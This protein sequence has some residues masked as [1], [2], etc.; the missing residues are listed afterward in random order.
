MSDLRYFWRIIY[1]S[2]GRQLWISSRPSRRAMVAWKSA[3]IGNPPT[4]T[5]SKTNTCGI[6]ILSIG[7]VESI[8]RV[9]GKDSIERRFFLASLPRCAQRL[10]KAIR[11]HW[12]VENPL[13][14]SLNVTFRE[15]D[16]RARTNNAAQ[17]LAML[18]RIV[19][20]LLKKDRSKKCSLRQKRLSAANNTNFLQLL[21]GI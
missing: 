20:N 15:D 1:F 13:H 18:R 14:W 8:R 9:N 6:R 4:L 12:G 7:M 2:R 21:L 11:G 17:N 19:L 16:S 5:G 3:A 10:A